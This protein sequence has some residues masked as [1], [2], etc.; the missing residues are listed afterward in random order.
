LDRG[1]DRASLRFL[2]TKEGMTVV[3][4]NQQLFKNTT[5]DVYKQFLSGMFTKEVYQKMRRAISE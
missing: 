3:E 4:V 5:K 1:V 2:P